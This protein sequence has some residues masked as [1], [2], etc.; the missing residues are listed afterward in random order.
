MIRMSMLRNHP[1][2]HKNKRIG[3]IQNLSVNLSQKRIKALIVSCGMKGKRILFPAQINTISEEFVLAEDTEKYRREYEDQSRAFVRNTDGRLIGY[4]TDYAIDEQTMSI[5]AVE[6]T[7][8]YL[9]KEKSIRVWIYTFACHEAEQWELI[10][11]SQI[12]SELSR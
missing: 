9:F 3:L 10:I 2:V 12:S 5:L 8:G 4:V 1:V 11:P 6:M 7:T